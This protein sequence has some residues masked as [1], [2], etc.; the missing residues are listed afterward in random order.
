MGVVKNF[1]TGT[2]WTL[3][4]ITMTIII[5]FLTLDYL[6]SIEIA[7]YPVTYYR[8]DFSVMISWIIRLGS[9]VCAIGFFKKTAP[10]G[11]RRAAWFGLFQTL[12]NIAYIFMYKFGGATEILLTFDFGFAIIGLSILLYLVMGRLVLNSFFNIY[13][14]IYNTWFYKEKKKTKKDK[15]KDKTETNVIKENNKPIFTDN[16]I[17]FE[18]PNNRAYFYSCNFMIII[19]ASLIM[20]QGDI[21]GQFYE[22]F[23]SFIIILG[24]I[25]EFFKIILLPLGMVMKAAIEDLSFY[26]IDEDMMYWIICIA[27]IIAAFI[28]NIK[29]PK[30]TKKA[31]TNI[32]KESNENY[33]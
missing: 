22:Y 12:A 13:N 14:I 25:I 9:I 21:F 30:R 11:S 17:K 5:P 1:L 20:F 6:T 15:T 4:Y 31:K 7:G 33:E 24:N 28:I 16:E 8:Y 27:I 18:K 29:W 2:L 32:E 10:K 19:T 3:Y 23:G 26:L